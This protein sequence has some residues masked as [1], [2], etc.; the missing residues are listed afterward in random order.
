MIFSP[1]SRLLKDQSLSGFQQLHSWG[2]SK[3]C[4]IKINVD[5]FFFLHTAATTLDIWSRFCPMLTCLRRRWTFLRFFACISLSSTMSSTWWRAVK[6]WRYFETFPSTSHVSRANR[7]PRLTALIWGCRFQGGLQEVAE[8]LE[9]ERIG[10]QHQAGSDSLLTG[11]AFFKMREVR[12]SSGGGE[13]LR[14]IAIIFLSCVFFKLPV[15]TVLQL[16]FLL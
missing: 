12:P 8:Q 10:P 6:T 13:H 1:S 11:M 14:F 15:F 3:I 7:E 9:L 16:L 4:S 5:S 2:C